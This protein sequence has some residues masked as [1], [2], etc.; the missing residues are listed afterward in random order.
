MQLQ[1]GQ[2]EPSGPPEKAWEL[3]I[4]G[5]S[6]VVISRVIIRVTIVMTHIKLKPYLLLPMNLQV[7]LMVSDLGF[8]VFNV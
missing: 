2:S 1:L 5:G 8:R 6:G 3:G 4:L 7:L